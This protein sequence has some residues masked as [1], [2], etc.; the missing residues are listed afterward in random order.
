VAATRHAT[1][2][3]RG[4][5]GLRPRSTRLLECSRRLRGAV[6][7]RSSPGHSVGLARRGPGSRPPGGRGHRIADRLVAR[8]GSRSARPVSARRGEPRRPASRRSRPRCSSACR[9]GCTPRARRVSPRSWRVC[10]SSFSLHTCAPSRARRL[11]GRMVPILP[12]RARSVFVRGPP[13][14]LGV[15]IDLSTLWVLPL[16]LTHYFW[17]R[18]ATVWPAMRRG[19]ASLPA[20]FSG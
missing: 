10:I 13:L 15:S 5:H 20:A 4:H 18:R 11:G 12:F 14:G 6:L 3:A 7:L 1:D 17:T 16:I 8:H 19:H 9:A 2:L